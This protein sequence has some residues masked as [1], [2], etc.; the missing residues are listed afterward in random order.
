M[1]S[2]KDFLL[3][4]EILPIPVGWDRG[5]TLPTKSCT[6]VVQNRTKGGKKCV[7]S[8]FPA[9]FL[10]IGSFVQ[11]KHNLLENFLGLAKRSTAVR[12]RSFAVVFFFSKSNPEDSK[13]TKN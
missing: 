8:S 5:K 6:K 13:P 1:G 4:G 10:P 11:K 12:A 2:V 3:S 7:G 9:I